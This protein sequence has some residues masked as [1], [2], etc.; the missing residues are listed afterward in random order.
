MKKFWLLGPLLGLSL[1]ADEPLEDNPPPPE[2]VEKQVVDAEKEFA[3]AQ[4]MFNPWYAGPLL[5]PSAHILTPGYVNIQP[6]LFYINNYAKFDE[7]GHSHKI[8]NTHTFNPIFPVL[9]GIL[10]W[11]DLSFSFQGVW[12]QAKKQYTG[13]WGDSKV[14]LG[15]GLL[16]EGPYRPAILFGISETFPSGRYQKLNPKK[17][18]T[19]AT[20]AGSYNTTLSL[21][22]SKV[23][24][25]LTLHPMNFRVSFNYTLPALVSVKGYNAYGGGTGTRGKVRPGNQFQGDF[26][27]EYS[28]TQKWVAALDV[29]Y[30]Y[31]R[32]TTFSGRSGFSSPG[33][34]AA[35]G[36]PSPSVAATMGGPFND[37][38]SL[39]PA[40]EYNPNEN[41]NFLVGTWF[42]VW[43]R[44][45]LN[46]ASAVVTVEYT[47]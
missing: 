45:A 46:F 2:V 40:L 14:G 6:Y 26:G 34:A 9:I 24:W 18:G 21:N 17:D 11:M 23:V 3:E 38:L 25:W 15:F 28:F 5:T 29:V 12:N 10:P 47:F 30:V 39:S 37:Q 16:H 22:L 7:H 4:K 33:S 41:L 1:F 19:D 20:G 13:F 42:S 8:S 44:N 43:G 36:G 31:N 27:Y 32:K 35:M